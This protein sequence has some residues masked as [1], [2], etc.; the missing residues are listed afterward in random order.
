MRH[1]GSDRRKT[2]GE[3]LK[4]AGKRVGAHPRLIGEIN[5]ARFG[6]RPQR[7]ST[8]MDRIPASQRTREKLKA[9]MEGR[10]EAEEGA[11]L[12]VRARHPL[13]D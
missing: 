8:P 5:E 4:L 11:G 10:S 13:G 1:G 12:V 9:L 7:R 6:D 2:N 3:V